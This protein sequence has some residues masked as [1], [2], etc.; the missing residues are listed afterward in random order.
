MDKVKGSVSQED[1][2]S[3]VRELNAEKEKYSLVIADCENLIL[4]MEEQLQI[5]PNKSEIIENY[6]NIQH[7]TRDIVETMIDKIV[8]GRRIKGTNNYPIDIYWNF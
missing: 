1:Y 3:I 5:K 4:S 6:L 7:L 2:D 8:V